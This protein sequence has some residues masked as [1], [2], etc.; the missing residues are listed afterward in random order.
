MFAEQ[1]R[2][3][4]PSAGNIMEE[5]GLKDFATICSIKALRRAPKLLPK[6]AVGGVA[7]LLLT[8][9]W[10][11]YLAGGSLRPN[12]FEV[13]TWRPATAEEVAREAGG[14]FRVVVF[15]GGDVATPNRF[16][17]LPEGDTTTWTEV[18]CQE[19]GCDSHIS[20]VPST[21]TPG[22]AIVSNSLFETALDRLS[23]GE[24]IGD[25]PSPGLDYSWVREHYPTPSHPDLASQ[26]NSFLAIPRPRIPPRETLWVFNFGFWDIWGLAAMPRRLAMDV[27]DSQAQHLFSYVEHLYN[28]AQNNASIAF[29]NH[30]HHHRRAHAHANNNN[31]HDLP[32]PATPPAS[33]S[34]TTRP[35]L[36]KILVPTLFDITLSPGFALS[37]RPPPAP[38]PPSAHLR[39]AAFL[40][41]YWDAALRAHA[42]AWLALPDPAAWAPGP[43]QDLLDADA[44]A[45]VKRAAPGTRR[46]RRDALVSDA[47][48]RYLR[49]VV[50]EGQL[51]GAAASGGDRD[52]DGVVG[53]HGDGEG[54][55]GGGGEGSF[56]KVRRPCVLGGSKGQEGGDGDGEEDG[57]G[58][59]HEIRDAN[60]NAAAADG[61]SVSASCDA[62]LFWTEFTVGPRAVAEVGRRAAE[63]IKKDARWWAEEE[64]EE[65]AGRDGVVDVGGTGEDD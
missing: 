44:A 39:N 31:N 7:F 19:L 51:R 42:S 32:L 10:L 61:D 63:Q 5:L 43:G 52:D 57:A 2:K 3:R 27:I 35:P 11:L 28:S 9:L 49:G 53:P 36:F 58:G 30:H 1:T 46:S 41:R 24:P 18:M 55:G 26:V 62:H 37:R 50:A 20:L 6:V 34:S 15:G 60:A 25:D 54:R 40:A 14:G 45:L 21:D 48:A 29:S 65:K 64:E 23:V 8:Y 33:S 22:G 56:A 4:L 47:G 13:N 59:G 38:H 12:Y 17:G 16:P